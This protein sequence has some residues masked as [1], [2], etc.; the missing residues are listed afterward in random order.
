MIAAGTNDGSVLWWNIALP[1]R[2]EA[3]GKICRALHRDLTP[4]ERSTCLTR[5]D[6]GPVCPT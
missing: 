4:Q 5:P 3:V 2:S 1:Q 6:T